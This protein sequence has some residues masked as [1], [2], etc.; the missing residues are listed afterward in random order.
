MEFRFLGG[1]LSVWQM[2]ARTWGTETGSAC[3]STKSELGNI[4]MKSL[5]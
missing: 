5:E 1:V 4:D 2:Q 3:P